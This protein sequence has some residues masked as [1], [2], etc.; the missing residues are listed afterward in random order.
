MGISLC[1]LISIVLSWSAYTGIEASDRDCGHEPTGHAGRRVGAPGQNRQK[2]N[3]HIHASSLFL[4]VIIPHLCFQIYVPPPDEGSRL[5]I[6]QLELSKMPL[7][8]EIDLPAL[9]QRTAGFSGA[10]IVGV[11]SEAAMLA[12]EAGEQYLR[13]EHLFA[14]T[15]AV[16][17]QIT[18][19]MLQFYQ[20]CAAKL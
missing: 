3:V 6:L 20:S 1:H 7:Q 18:E 17:P 2:G 10:E 15:A 16:K 8:D 13:P 5:Q 4:Y 14:A 11:C 19:E 12:I 9:V